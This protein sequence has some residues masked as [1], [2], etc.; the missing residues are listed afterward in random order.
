MPDLSADDIR[1][2]LDLPMTDTQASAL[3][4]WYASLSAAVAAFPEGDLRGIEPPLRSTPAPRP[5]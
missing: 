5:R 4:A 3:A 1:R 2:L